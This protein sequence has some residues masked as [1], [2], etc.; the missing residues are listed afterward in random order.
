[1]Q[2]SESIAVLDKEKARLAMKMA[3][4]IQTYARMELLTTYPV[5][6]YKG[7]KV[8]DD[9]A[10]RYPKVFSQPLDVALLKHHQVVFDSCLQK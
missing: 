9:K 5:A 2:L 1:M 7:E 6:L 8:E 3:K 10:S 4:C